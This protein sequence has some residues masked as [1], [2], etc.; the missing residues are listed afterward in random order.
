MTFV[1]AWIG[2]AT[3]VLFFNRGA[4]CDAI[5]HETTRENVGFPVFRERK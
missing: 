1:I 2:L 5:N 3:L 4:T